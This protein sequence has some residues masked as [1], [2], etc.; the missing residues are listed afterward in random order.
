M[1]Y[2][3]QK[4]LRLK[5][6]CSKCSE[7]FRPTSAGSRVCNLCRKK[8]LKILHYKNIG[9]KRDELSLCVLKIQ[10]NKLREETW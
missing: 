8:I 7:M 4:G 2:Y 1:S 5:R 10:M 3:K 9:Q 6:P